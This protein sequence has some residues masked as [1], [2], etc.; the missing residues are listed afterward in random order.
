MVVETQIQARQETISDYTSLNAEAKR[1]LDFKKKNIKK[2]NQSP[3]PEC[4]TL[5]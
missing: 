4:A 2:H 5:I 1:L 3:C